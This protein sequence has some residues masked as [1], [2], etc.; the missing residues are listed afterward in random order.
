MK[1][2]DISTD[3][4]EKYVLHSP[5]ETVFFMLNRVGNITFEL[6][7]PETKTRILS[8]TLGRDGGDI[9]LNVTQRHLAQ[10]T[11]SRLYSKNVLAGVTHFS[12]ENLIS[13]EKEAH[14]SDAH[15]ESRNLLVSEDSR[16][17][18]KPAL[19]IKTDDVRCTHAATTS[20]F[21]KEALFFAES[22]GLSPKDAEK[23]LAQ[24]FALSVLEHMPD[25]LKKER[26]VLEKKIKT[27]M[28]KIFP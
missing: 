3:T 17:H 10:K 7:K 13:L 18:S 2:Q 4:N 23:L 26:K 21:P 19:E 27:E 15:Q 12:G 16:A 22:R 8:L 6:A 9:A 28:E 24:G 14:L 25:T 11:R 5:E 20:T 1:F